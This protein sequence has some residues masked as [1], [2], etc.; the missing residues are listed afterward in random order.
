MPQKKKYRQTT[1]IIT[2]QNVRRA[3]NAAK[4]AYKGYKVYN[5]VKKNFTSRRSSATGA[6][7][8]ELQMVSYKGGKKQKQNLKGAWK[9]IRANTQRNVYFYENCNRYLSNPPSPGAFGIASSFYG[10]TASGLYKLPLH[11]YSLS[12]VPNV[13]NGTITN[14]PAM[15]A[16]QKSDTTSNS[17]PTF[18]SIGNITAQ[19]VAG[20]SVAYQSYPQ[21]SD[22]LKAISTKLVLYG[23]L[24]RPIK[25]LIQ[26]VQFRKSY[27][28]PDFIN[29]LATAA[30]PIAQPEMS[31]ASAFYD[32]LTKPYTYSPISFNDNTQN[33]DLKVIK[34]WVHIIQPKTNLE[35]SVGLRESTSNVETVGAMPHSKIISIYQ[36]FNRSSKYDWDNSVASALPTSD[37][38]DIIPVLTGGNK[39]DVTY[40]ARMYLMV[41]A[42]SP[43]FTYNTFDA[44]VSGSYDICT[45]YYHE[46]QG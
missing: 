15:W 30:N 23:S 3:H 26:I 37:G 13:N 18:I 33:R 22:V 41:R 17:Y 36:K 20:S 21:Q 8:S 16:L 31:K 32:N 38:T 24:T 40:N 29:G 34:S 42:L 28:H 10:S 45:R 44:G 27:L 35:A 7:F 9:V 4:A 5:N 19:N 43:V 12:A 2:P 11:L 14:V 25:Y 39:T 1:K 6:P 46:N